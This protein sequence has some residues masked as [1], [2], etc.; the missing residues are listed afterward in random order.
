MLVMQQVL[1][2]W[3]HSPEKVLKTSP[4][5]PVLVVDEV[6]DAIPLARAL[7]EGGISV[8]E[9]TLRSSA[10][11]E[12]IMTI[13]NE[14]PE[15]MVG[16]GT[17]LNPEDLYG[18]E[19]AGALFAISPGITPGLL[20]ASFKASIPLI[21]GV[22]TVS[23]LMLGLEA[24]LQVFKF[25]PAEAAGGVRILSALKGPFP[26]VKFCPT[27]GINGENFLEYL[28]LDNVIS[29]GGSWVAPREFIRRGR[30][31]EISAMVKEALMVAGRG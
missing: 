7:L 5:I 29:V 14:V 3:R 16:A 26:K 25:F 8:L 2:S 19:K 17:V 27:G 28:A 23:E 18:V 1:R 20:E 22:S 9:I 30:W 21:P 13:R 12:A 24:G 11:L 10:A 6:K 31:G 15:A 4:I